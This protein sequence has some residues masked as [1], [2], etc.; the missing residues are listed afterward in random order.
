MC[1]AEGD[2]AGLAEA[3]RSLAADS[4]GRKRMGKNARDALVG[5]YDA[6]TL[7]ARWIDMLEE[8][9]QKPSQQKPTP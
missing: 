9:T 1:F 7:C 6:D 5:Q 2:S 3:V 4:I 8:L